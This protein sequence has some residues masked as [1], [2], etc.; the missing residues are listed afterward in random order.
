[1]SEQFTTRPKSDPVE[2][3]TKWIKLAKESGVLIGFVVTGTLL[4]ANVTNS[5]ESL[6]EANKSRIVEIKALQ[7][8][9]QRFSDSVSGK[10]DAISQHQSDQAL[11]L[12]RIATQLEMRGQMPHEFQ[13]N[14]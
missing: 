11:A 6:K 9:Q 8:S 7:D 2:S 12:T 5:I 14:K 4:Y 3:A 13:R 1:M 10:L